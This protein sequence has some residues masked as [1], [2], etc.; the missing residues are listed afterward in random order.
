MDV[1]PRSIRPEDTAVNL[2]EFYADQVFRIGARRARDRW[3]V[4]DYRDRI[5]SGEFAELAPLLALCYDHP[6]R[7]VLQRERELIQRMDPAVQGEMLAM[8]AAVGL[9]CVTQQIVW[10]VFRGEIDTMKSAGFIQE[11]LTESR[12]QGRSEEARKLALTL[13]TKRFGQLPDELVVR[14]QN[15]GGDWCEQVITSALD[16]SRLEDLDLH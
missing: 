3:G 9:R 4:W 15:A 6:G 7:R 12:E 14:I 16:A 13:L 10:D 2:P 11:W 5:E 1:A 8:A